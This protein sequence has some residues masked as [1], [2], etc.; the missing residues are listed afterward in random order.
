MNG[1]TDLALIIP[2]LTSKLSDN[3]LNTAIDTC[4]V[5]IIK[6]WSDENLCESLSVK[7]KSIFK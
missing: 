5:E 3:E 2:A 4:T 7:R 1:I 6:K